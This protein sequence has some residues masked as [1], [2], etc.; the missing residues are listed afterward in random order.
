MCE[1]C[2]VEDFSRRGLLRSA[3]GAALASGLSGRVSLAEAWAAETLPGDTVEPEEI[4]AGVFFHKGDTRY[5]QEGVLNGAAGSIRYL[6]CNNG[7]IV[8]DDH[9]LVID[10]N[11][12]GRAEALVSAV[13]RTTN[14][15]SQSN[16]CSIRTIMGTMCTGIAPWWNEL[17]LP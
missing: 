3:A 7:W 9:V 16:I 8:L 2:L 1:A 17:E 13:R 10:A 15:V 14:A 6:M 11:M 4:A 12:P 5:F